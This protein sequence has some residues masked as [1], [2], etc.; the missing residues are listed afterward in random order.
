[1]WWDPEQLDLYMKATMPVGT[2]FSIGFGTKEMH[3]SDIVIW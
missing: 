3:N 1:M 2:W